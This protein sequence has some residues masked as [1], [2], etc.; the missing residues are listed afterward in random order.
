VQR[1]QA[2]KVNAEG[3]AAPVGTSVAG[4]GALSQP[5]SKTGSIER[6]TFPDWEQDLHYRAEPM[7][8]LPVEAANSSMSL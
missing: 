6:D 7:P 4:G 2:A 5:Q 8:A 1:Q 3:G